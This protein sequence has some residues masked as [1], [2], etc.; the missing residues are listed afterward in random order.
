MADA[1]GDDELHHAVQP[2]ILQRGASLAHR[3]QGRDSGVLLEQ[4]GRGAGA[5]FHAVDHDDVGAGLGGEL[6]VVVDPA[7]AELDEDRH[8]PVGRLAQLL[9]LDDHVVGADKVRMARRAPLV[10]AG[11]QIA[12]RGDLAGDLRPE[13]HAARRRL[14]PLPDRQLDRIGRAEVM[15]VDTV[16]ARQHL[17]DQ[18]A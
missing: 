3:G 17:V 16:A 14:R 11:R 4:V 5:A 13:Q 18:H 1:A 12:S 6:D 8:L 15:H 9:D 10:D 7:G 2:E